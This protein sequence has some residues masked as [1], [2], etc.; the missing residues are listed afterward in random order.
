MIFT[1]ARV[2]FALGIGHYLSA[3]KGGG[4]VEGFRGDHLIFGRTKGVTVVTD[5]PKGGI[6][7]DFGRLGIKTWEEGSRKSFKVTGGGG[8]DH[9]GDVTFKGGI[10]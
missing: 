6:A 5:N 7:G 10:G 9:F 3:E 2:S 1:R 8:G 4:G